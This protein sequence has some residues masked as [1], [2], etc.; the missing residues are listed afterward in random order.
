VHWDLLA[1]I[2][3]S[4]GVLQYSS[5]NTNDYSTRFSTS[6]NQSYSVDTNGQAITWAGVLTS[7]GGTLTKS[8]LGTLTLT[9]SLN[10]YSGGT[11]INGGILAI[12]A[13]SQLG[14]I[15]SLNAAAITLN[16]GSLQ[17]NQS[18]TLNTNRGITLG[19]NDGGLAALSG[20]TLTYG[21]IIADGSST[22]NLSINTAGQVGIVKLT[23]SNTFGGD[24]TIYAGTLLIS[25]DS[26]LGSTSGSYSKSTAGALIL[27]GGT[28][29][30]SSNLTLNANR[31]IS[32]KSSSGGLAASA[33]VLLKYDGT[34]A[35]GSSTYSLL[36]NGAGQ[37]GSVSLSGSN[38]YGGDTY[39]NGGTLVLA[40][41]GT[42]GNSNN[43][44]YLNNAVLDLQTSL[45]LRS[46]VM[47]G[48]TTNII[49][50]TGSSSIL[51]KGDSTLTG[52]ITTNG[53]QTYSGTVTLNGDVTLNTSNDMLTVGYIYGGG[54]NFTTNSGT[55]NQSMGGGEFINTLTLDPT[56]NSWYGDN[57]Y[58]SELS[59]NSHATITQ[60]GIVRKSL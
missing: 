59:N 35:D 25:A 6:S 22:N 43:T 3:F 23:G 8:G 7:S 47:Q 55:G 27:A 33:N 51:V 1:V 29:Q 48:I 34:I 58:S 42:L 15:L 37:T 32:L 60:K 21:G 36:I 4:G 56:Y 2:T 5:S 38:A 11:T 16:G 19:P 9:N 14:R 53:T 49:N 26:A 18:F 17:A 52:T 45:T 39:V 46:L 28:L 57:N 44:L 54:Y 10:T 20:V 12:S 24:T 30:A 13:D 50:S 31:D 40:S 41:G